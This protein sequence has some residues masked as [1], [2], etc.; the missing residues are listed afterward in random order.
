MKKTNSLLTMLLVTGI[1]ASTVFADTSI[2]NV[3]KIEDSFVNLKEIKRDI[4][5]AKSA[6]AD[7]MVFNKEY[8]KSNTNIKRRNRIPN[9][10]VI[11]REVKPP[12]NK[13]EKTV[14]ELN[15]NGES[16]GKLK[17][18]N[19]P[20]ATEKNTLTKNTKAKNQSRMTKR[21]AKIYKAIFSA[22][23]LDQLNA[24]QKVKLL[25]LHR[26]VMKTPEFVIVSKSITKGED[27]GLVVLVGR[28][29]GKS[30]KFKEIMAR[31]NTST[32]PAYQFPPKMRCFVFNKQVGR[33]STAAGLY[34][35]TKTNFDYYAK[36]F[37]LKDFSVET[38]NIILLEL[39]RTSKTKVSGSYVGRGYVEL[40]KHNYINA[41]RFGSNDFASS[42]FSEW[43]GRKAPLLKIAD[44]VAKRIGVE[45][46]SPNLKYGNQ[47][48]KNLK[49][50]NFFQNWLNEFAK[51]K[52]S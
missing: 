32:H 9:N 3:N 45:N 18:T 21:D 38:Q 24:E 23:R 52:N 15:K 13:P 35:E 7:A 44:S 36:H 48:A 19:F 42:P 40:L 29:H 43:G 12:S 26:K 4:I 11:R 51:D 5:Q 27:G 17:S 34:Q 25:N 41:I 2:V 16:K 46:Q 49:D 8:V 47:N 39:M 20:N 28:G 1:S 14:T 6:T 37:G 31:L 10:L 22:K 50:K 33:C 30:K